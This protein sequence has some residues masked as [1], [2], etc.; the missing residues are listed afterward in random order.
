MTGPEWSGD[1]LRY[2]RS[3][4]HLGFKSIIIEVQEKAGGIAEALGLAQ[5]FV[6]DKKSVIIL[7][8]NIFQDRMNVAVADF[9]KQERGAKIFIK[10][11]PNPDQYGVPELKGE[12]VVRIVEKPAKGREPSRYAVT[13]LYM[14]D[15]EVFDIVK[16]LKPSARGE[17]EITDVNNAYIDRG[18]LTYEIVKGVWI[19]AG[20]H[21]GRHFAEVTVREW[22][23]QGRWSPE[24]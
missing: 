1:F 19:D 5:P 14:Y 12:R 11:V 15:G 22:E 10:E 17:L 2:V 20:S 6:E 7:G 13:G 23:S 3:G 9:E 8:D 18:T 16:G 21:E 4:R 24:F